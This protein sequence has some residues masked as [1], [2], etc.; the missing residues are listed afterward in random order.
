M[1]VLGVAPAAAQ[2]A[3]PPSW[4]GSLSAYTY[5]IPG[6]ENYAQPT[7][8]ADRAWMHLEAR[9]NYE[10]LDTASA[11]FGYNF[12]GG[13]TVAWSLTPMLGGAFGDVSGMAPGYS[14][15]LEWKKLEA[16]SEGELFFDFSESSDSFL[17]NWS[18]IALR[19]IPRLR[20]GLVTQRTRVRASP[21]EIQRGPLVGFDIQNLELTAY[22]LTDGSSRLTAVLSFGWTFGAE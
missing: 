21:R 14:A 9:Y 15:S 8:A 22:V 6:A 1:V 7:V 3:E 11:W 2:D 5:V 17:Y 12:E 13:N 19:P 4:S 20:I 10:A 18:E 16:Y